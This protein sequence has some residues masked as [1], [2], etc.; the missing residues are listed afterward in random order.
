MSALGQ[1]RTLRRI[2][3]MPALPPKADFVKFVP[4][5]LRRKGGVGLRQELIAISNGKSGNGCG[6]HWRE[7]VC[8]ATPSASR[9]LHSPAHQFSDLGDLDCETE[10]TRTNPLHR[11]QIRLR[12]SVRAQRCQEVSEAPPPTARCVRPASSQYKFPLLARRY[13]HESVGRIGHRWN[14]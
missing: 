10:L 11:E 6:L 3:P 9:C 1:K 2:Q 7:L 4:V 12:F 8:S 14:A 13:L 5:A